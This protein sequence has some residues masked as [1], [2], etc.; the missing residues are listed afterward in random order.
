[1]KTET[2]HPYRAT[3]LVE[4]RR[5]R[6]YRP[7]FRAL[8]AVALLCVASGVTSL[9]VLASGCHPNLGPVVN[10]RVGSY[11]C[12]RGAPVVCSQSQRWQPVGNRDCAAVGAVCVAPT[13]G[14]AHC[15]RA[16]SDAAAE[17]PGASDG[18]AE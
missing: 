17:A 6:D 13:D 1:M 4:P 9:V 2:R 16:Q 15:A 5:P 3:S 12:V 18:G 7:L 14:P 8:Y 11:E 10:C